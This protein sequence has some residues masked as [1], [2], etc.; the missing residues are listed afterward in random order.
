M[1]TATALSS[2]PLLRHPH[3]RQQAVGLRASRP[4]SAPRTP[5]T[6]TVAAADEPRSSGGSIDNLSTTYCDDFVCTSSPAVEQTVRS[7]ATDLERCDGK[8]TTK[9]FARNVKYQDPLRRFT[10]K[11][12]YARLDWVVHNVADARAE[13]SGMRM[14]GDGGSEAE[15]AW[16]LRGRLGVLPL[17]LP[18]TTTI[19]M[20]LVTGQIESHRESWQLGKASPLAALAWMASRA[21]WSS[22]QASRDAADA[23]QSMLNSLT[24]VDEDEMSRGGFTA[25]PTDPNKFFQNSPDTFRQDAILFCAVVGLLYVLV[26]AWTMLETGKL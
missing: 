25:D 5:R 6:C 19:K 21:L 7:L 1:V 2:T 23:A 8:W 11:E 22:Q 9:L 15:I 24:S 20:N 14:L 16:T 12:G 18:G 3:G 13:V 10:G 17:S 26:Q 4:H